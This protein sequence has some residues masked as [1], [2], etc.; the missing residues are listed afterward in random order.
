MNQ[1]FS[2]QKKFFRIKDRAYISGRLWVGSS[3]KSNVSRILQI[4]TIRGHVNIPVSRMIICNRKPQDEYFECSE[5][6]RVRFVQYDLLSSWSYTFDL[7]TNSCSSSTLVRPQQSLKSGL[8]SF[9]LNFGRKFSKCQSQNEPNQ[10]KLKIS[11]T[12]ASNKN[13][14]NSNFWFQVRNKRTARFDDRPVRKS[15]TFIWS[16]SQIFPD[17]SVL[18]YGS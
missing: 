11:S 6:F 13:D 16:G 10:N 9:D 17:Q 14:L 12:W 2:H 5:I 18:V 3:D 1:N 15:P 8:R 7:E 4:Q